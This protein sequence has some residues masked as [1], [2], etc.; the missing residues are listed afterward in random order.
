MA[1]VHLVTCKIP[2]QVRKALSLAVKRGELGHWKKD[3]KKPEAYFHP[4]FEHLAR[5]ARKE[6]ENSKTQS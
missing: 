5:Q 3:E 2:A 6:H 1:R 4:D